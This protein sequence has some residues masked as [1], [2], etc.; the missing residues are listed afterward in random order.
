MLRELWEEGGVY[1][2]GQGGVGQGATTGVGQAKAVFPQRGAC[3]PVCAGAKGEVIW[4]RPAGENG[5]PAGT[6]VGRP[7]QEAGRPESAGPSQCPPAEA[8]PSPSPRSPW[9][10]KMAAKNRNDL[11]PLRS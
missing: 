1:D 6:K 9:I 3:C 7:T 5:W 11:T 10:F 4:F 2:E 8:A